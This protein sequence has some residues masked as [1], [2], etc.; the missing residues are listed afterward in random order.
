LAK[1]API[2]TPA[3]SEID[4][5][6]FIVR[7]ITEEKKIKRQVKYKNRLIKHLTSIS[8]GPVLHVIEED[9]IRF[10][11]ISKNSSS[12]TGILD[13]ELSELKWLDMIHGHDREN[14]I[15]NLLEFISNPKIL[16]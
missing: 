12:L 5:F 13:K 9:P 6:I 2:Q 15:S 8:N 10:K 4:E 14:V 3:L 11:F 16:Y 1:V 7:E